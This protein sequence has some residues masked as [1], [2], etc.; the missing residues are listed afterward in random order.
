MHDIRFI[1]QEPEAFDQGLAKR[2][3]EALSA[4]LMAQDEALRSTQT[5]LQELQNRRNAA[6]KSIGK[7]KREGGDV[8]ALMAEVASIKDRI[9][10]LEE[11]ERQQTA[12]LTDKL[13]SLPNL[14]FDEVPVGNDEEDNVEVSQWGEKPTL[15]F[16]A[17]QHFELGEQLE[18]M[19]FDI[20]G[21]LS[22][23]RFVVL[24]GALARLERALVQ[25]MLN[26]HTEEFGY[27]EI[28]PP[29]LVRDEALYGTSQLPKF[30]EDLFRT[31]EGY[32]LIPTSEVPLTNLAREQIL[33]ESK[34][35]LRFTAFSPCF[36]SEAGSAG[37][38]T[39]G[40][41]R[42]HQFHKVELVSIT[43]PDKSEEEHQ[44]MTKCAE[45][46]LQRLGLHYRT[47]LLCSGDMGFGARKTFDLEVWLPGQGNYREIS[48]CSNCGDFQ[49]RRMKA[50]FRPTGEKQTQF[51][52]ALNGSGLATGR[53]L[54]A[55]MENYQREDGSIA[56]PDVLLPY[57]GGMTEIRI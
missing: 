54:I 10:E 19:D 15:A 50:R 20:A 27:T 42:Q 36:R 32:W 39:R 48:S 9:G 28:V 4:T 34:L 23:A 30:A 41:F 22:G 43:H 33:D 53:C 13:S 11:Q 45:T 37:K 49:A 5:E 7:V 46:I 16:E 26:T 51:V 24:R 3:L 14:P 57:M 56:I 8:D 17:K 2:G 35:P 44:R 38:D 52:H 40:M 25:F 21:K 55:V 29:Y 1:R 18:M 47:M 31:E 6:S 12:E